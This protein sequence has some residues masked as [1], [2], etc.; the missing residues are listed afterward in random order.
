MLNRGDCPARLGSLTQDKADEYNVDGKFVAIAGY[1]WTSQ[2]K[3]WTDVATGEE[4]ERLFPGVPKFYNHKNV[5]FPHRVDD[6][7]RAKDSAYMTPDLLAEAVRKAGGLIHNNHPDKGPD[8][9]DQWDYTAAASEVIVNTEM[10]GDVL[11]YEGKTYQ[12]D[13][14]KAVCAFLNRGG[15]TGFVR[16]T[17]S[18]EGKPEART[19]ALA[20]ELTRESLF[21]ALRHRRNYAVSYARIGLEFTLCGHDMGE[22]CEIEG[23]PILSIKVLGTDIVTDVRDHPRWEIAA[24][25][26]S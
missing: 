2:S 12:V 8:G 13:M 21:E 23:K 7:F 3:Y 14:E 18:H 11:N 15:R 20:K 25:H 4:S 10:Y 24:E 26:Q 5:Y 6:I 22:E 17:D 9:R 19:A 16:G 1:E